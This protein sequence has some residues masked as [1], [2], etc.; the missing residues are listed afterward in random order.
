MSQGR[1]SPCDNLLE[2]VSGKIADHILRPYQKALEIY[3]ASTVFER[4]TNARSR[5][6]QYGF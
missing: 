4:G 3:F 1:P 5:G 2:A 6:S